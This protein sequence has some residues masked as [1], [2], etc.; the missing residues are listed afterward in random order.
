MHFFI[1]NHKLTDRLPN[2]KN[3]SHS[4]RS[5]CAPGLERNFALKSPKHFVSKPINISGFSINFM[6]EGQS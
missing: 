2:E 4:E 5:A 3:T 1:A 6:A